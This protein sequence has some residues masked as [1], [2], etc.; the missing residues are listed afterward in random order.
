MLVQDAAARG[1]QRTLRAQPHTAYALHPAA[2]FRAPTLDFLIQRILHALA[3]AGDTPGGDTHSHLL[4]KLVLR[5]AFSFGD[6]VKLFWSHVLPR[7]CSS[8]SW[9]GPLFQPLLQAG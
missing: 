7:R 5:F 2:L 6:L 4:W 9:T 3:L 1:N 8:K